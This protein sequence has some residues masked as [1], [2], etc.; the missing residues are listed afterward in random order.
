MGA[1]L[2]ILWP[3]RYSI[4][5]IVF[6]ILSTLGFVQVNDAIELNEF[7][8]EGGVLLGTGALF[9]IFMIEARYASRIRE[10]KARLALDANFRLTER[11]RDEIASKNDQL[12]DQAK[13]LRDAKERIEQMN[14]KLLDYNSELES[15]VETRTQKLKKANKE[16][17]QLVYSLSHDFRTPMVNVK[18][19]LDFTEQIDSLDQMKAVMG[20]MRSAVHRFDE[21][22]SDMMNY[23]VYWDDTVK[24]EKV[25]IPEIIANE[26]RRFDEK[27]DGL[28]SKPKLETIGFERDKLILSDFEKLRTVFYCLFSNAIRYA[29]NEE[30][31]FVRVEYTET[32]AEH[33]ITITDNGQGIQEEH[34]PKVFD[35]FYRGHPKSQGAGMG[36]YIA[37]EIM[38]QLTGKIS[39]ESQIGKGTSVRISIPKA[40]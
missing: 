38:K 9:T 13:K 37:K 34:L 1:A 3:A 36:L 35:M 18:G 11:Q 28:N 25:L 21:L 4:I 15:Q 16:M 27:A 22:L 40:Q 19:L 24:T 30:D 17:D 32:D 2:F 23:A 31:S 33:Q 10:I 6:S 39:L 29:K 12:E 8:V 20:K 7:A 14:S 26:W 5:I